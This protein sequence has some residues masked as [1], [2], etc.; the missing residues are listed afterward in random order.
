[1]CQKREKQKNGPGIRELD[2]QGFQWDM[3]LDKAGGIK[4]IF[5][6]SFR[7]LE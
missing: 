3:D 1:M 7:G 5:T 2:L 4:P 6:T